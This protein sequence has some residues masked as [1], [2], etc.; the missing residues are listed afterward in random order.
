MKRTIYNDAETGIVVEHDTNDGGKPGPII[1]IRASS[2]RTSPPWFTEAEAL[3]VLIG[4][5]RWRDETTV[6]AT[7]GHPKTASVHHP[8]Y[9]RANRCDFKRST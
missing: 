4:L 8:T 7:C 2:N 6:C 5:S 3:A 9:D 1:I